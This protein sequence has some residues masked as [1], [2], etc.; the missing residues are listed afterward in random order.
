M[1][2]QFIKYFKECLFG[3]DKQII[4][5][6]IYDRS[7]MKLAFKL[8][9]WAPNADGDARISIPY[10]LSEKQ[11]WFRGYYLTPIS[12]RDVLTA[13]ESRWKVDLIQ[14]YFPDKK[15]STA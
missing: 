10:F 5:G 7:K 13:L 2:K 12:E 6:V 8:K 3:P 14:Q 11:N 15:Y 1:M 4:N 9:H